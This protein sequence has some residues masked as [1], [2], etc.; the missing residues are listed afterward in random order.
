MIR[1]VST[2]VGC[3]IV[4]AHDASCLS[5]CWVPI[6]HE[7]NIVYVPEV[8]AEVGGADDEG[9]SWGKGICQDLQP[10]ARETH[11]GN[12]LFEPFL[13]PCFASGAVLFRRSLRTFPHRDDVAFTV[14][15][16]PPVMFLLLHSRPVRP[17]TRVSPVEKGGK[18]Q[19]KQKVISLS[20]D[21]EPK[22]TTFA[23]DKE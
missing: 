21:A 9:R 3:S 7:G 12:T 19:K 6:L 15:S 4:H 5:C 1:I 23:L 13:F 16:P 17:S 18:K 14:H 8:W 22:C 20:K 2:V 10:H 11:G